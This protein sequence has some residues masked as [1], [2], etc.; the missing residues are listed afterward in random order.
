MRLRRHGSVLVCAIALFWM[1][2]GGAAEAQ[3]TAALGQP[4]LP[5]GKKQLAYMKV[6]M[7]GFNVEEAGRRAPVNVALV[8]DRSGSMEGEKLQGAKQAAIEALDLLDSNDIL[9]VIAF[10][11]TVEV[12]LPATKLTD[13]TAVRAAIERINARGET[14]L[15]AGVTKGAEELRKFYDRGRVNR[16]I[17]LTDGQAN[18]GPSSAADLG[19]LG[20]SLKKEGISV[21]T[22][23]LGLDYNEDL[24][25]QLAKMSDGNHSFL[26]TGADISRVFHSEL[27]YV[28]KVVA[29]EISIR[30]QCAEGIRPVRVLGREAEISGQNILVQ[31]NQ[32]YSKHEQFF[33]LELEIP[34]TPDGQK[35][36]I[37]SVSATYSNMATHSVEK[38]QATVSANFS[39]S[40]E[41]VDNAEDKKVMAS[42]IAMVSVGN[43]IM[44][45]ALHDQGKVEEAKKVLLDNEEFIR[46]NNSRLDSEDLRKL[47]DVN[48][49]N[50][51]DMSDPEHWSAGRKN[52]RHAQSVGESQVDE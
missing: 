4:T 13:K 14:A 35:R 28:L 33:V 38:L 24:L 48:K 21:T 31:I 50:R 37:A 36:E 27:G 34:A 6:G 29:Q 11:S 7:T 3:L 20:A 26:K 5:A 49:Q 47:E 40:K 16:V 8:L 41:A 39:V 10:D 22:L 45:T 9:S 17:L 19:N 52:M 46:G 15:F 23:G 1:S 44:A 30:I 51:K 25:R 2:A 12:V 43:N 32:L 18:V 42:C